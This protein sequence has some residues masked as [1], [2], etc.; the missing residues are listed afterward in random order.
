MITTKQA[1]HHDYSD[2]L[3]EVTKHDDIATEALLNINTIKSYLNNVA[4]TEIAVLALD[5]LNQT[6]L[7]MVS[8]SVARNKATAIFLCELFNANDISVKKGL[9]DYRAFVDQ[10][11]ALPPWDK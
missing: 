8:V 7:K 11:D 5:S 10:F 6:I 4:D 9:A 3:V 2:L 1:Y